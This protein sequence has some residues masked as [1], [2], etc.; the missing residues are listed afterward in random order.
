MKLHILLNKKC[1]PLK[2]NKP[3]FDPV[4][5]FD[6]NSAF[7]HTTVKLT[8]KIKMPATELADVFQ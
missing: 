6:W 7:D 2:G 5:K 3:T 4:T 8:P 1:D